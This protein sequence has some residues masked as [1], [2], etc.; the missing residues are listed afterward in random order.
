[1]CVSAC[2]AGALWILLAAGPVSAGEPARLDL[3]QFLALNATG[4]PLRR[5]VAP[6]IDPAGVGWAAADTV[7]L[8]PTETPAFEPN[9]DRLRKVWMRPSPPP[10]LVFRE[11]FPRRRSIQDRRSEGVALVIRSIAP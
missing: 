2:R 5:A 9:F 11:P 10:P 3:T 7:T 6:G 1:M 8:S 4:G